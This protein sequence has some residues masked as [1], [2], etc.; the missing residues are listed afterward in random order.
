M[1][2]LDWTIVIGL[3]GGII[4]YGLY[5][6]R[7]LRSSTD[8]FLAGR[9]LPWWI[10]GLSMYATAIDASDLIADSGG[11]YTMGFRYFVSNMVGIVAGWALAAHFIFLPMYRAGMYTNAEY[12]EA[13]FGPSARVL[14]A[15][16]QV[17]YRTLVLG[18]MGVSLF[19]TLNVICD[20]GPAQSMG[21]V[22]AI[23]AFASIY[24]AFGGLRSVAVSDVLQFLVMTL[25]ALIIWFVVFEKI[26][27]WSGLEER[28]S[29]DPE[30]S[31]LLHAGSDLPSVE[32]VNNKTQQEIDRK[33]L[34]GG[35]YSPEKGTITRITPNWLLALGFLILGVG[36][37]VVNHTQSMRM[38]AARTEWDL[39]MSVVVAGLVMI[40]MSFFNLSMG[41][42]GRAWVPNQAS[43]PGGNQDQIYPLLVSQ[44]E[45]VGLK[46]IVV[47]G[48]F[49]ASF[50]T[51]DSIGS[52]LSA[53]LTRDVYAR[54]LVRDRDD[55]HY[56]RVGQWLTPFVIGI[57]FLY[58]PSLL[59]GG[60]LLQFLA[61]TS[62]FVTPLL[63]LFIMGR[64]TRVHR[65]S[66]TVGLLV[67]TA[68][69]ILRLLAPTI[70]EN[71][72]IAI[73]P[74]YLIDPY[75][76]YP[77]AMFV[78]AGAMVLLSLLL[79]FEP[80]A[81]ANLGSQ[82]EQGGAWLS[83]SRKAIQELGVQETSTED[84][85]PGAA[86]FL[87]TVLVWLVLL[88]GCYLCFVYFW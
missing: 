56:L 4:G 49:A 35:D 53:L 21:T 73:L 38:F 31:Q 10:V 1:T 3:N 42:L 11:T 27:G 83:A 43:L 29:V 88:L 48:I 82:E 54:L 51:Y 78:T 67:G 84:T 79:G 40:V 72:G 16:V 65:V 17:Q 12:L 75:A 70:A 80:P 85:S 26:G 44:L 20:W 7:G 55:H 41:V 63:T 87:P 60:M 57:S 14:C 13:R 39:K 71:W 34:L 6:A 77:A 52:T 50:S 24:T 76:A 33:L 66:G 68:F 59:K 2:T 47:A 61:L 74:S 32:D 62:A 86:R 69:G 64:F 15:F 81:K 30:L 5:L 23:A 36:Y 25:A 18:V 58:V 28:L 46:G 9:S 45:T 22:V 19:L 8:W 37:A